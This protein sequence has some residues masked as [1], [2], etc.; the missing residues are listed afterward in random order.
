MYTTQAFSAHDV[1][2]IT[3]AEATNYYK[4]MVSM[5]EEYDTLI[6]NGTQELVPFEVEMK[7]I[8]NRWVSRIK[9]KP[10]R[11]I[12]RLNSRVVTK[13]YHQVEGMDYFE[14]FSPIVKHTTIRLILTLDMSKK[15]VLR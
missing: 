6:K 7:V 12:D 13:G 10:I 15:W 1:E 11:D 14:T 4:W 3:F 9:R 2:L 5:K 8:R